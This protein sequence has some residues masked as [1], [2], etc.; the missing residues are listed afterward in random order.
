MEPPSVDAGRLPSRAMRI[1]P[2]ARASCASAESPASSVR[3]KSS[4]ASSRP[5]STHGHR[6]LEAATRLGSSSRP[7]SAAVTA[8]ASRACKLS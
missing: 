5:K 6:P 4:S 2:V 7:A 1:R 8:Q 3:S